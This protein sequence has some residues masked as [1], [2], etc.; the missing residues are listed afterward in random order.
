MW[1]VPFEGG[2][3]KLL[4]EG[5]RPA[6]SPRGDVVAFEKERQVWSAPLDGSAPAKKLFTTRGENGGV[7]WAP[8]GSR[9]AFVSKRDAHA[10][11]GVYQDEATPIRWIAPSTS[12]DSSPRFSPDGKRL[13]FVRRPGTG[14]AAP[15]IHE[16]RHQPR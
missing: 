10:L 6:L 11:V 4:G 14:G 3:P 1:S 5:D 7:E 16:P 9:F 15:P 8:D 2:E 13:V 12:R